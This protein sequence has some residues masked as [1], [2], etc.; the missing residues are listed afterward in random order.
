MGNRSGCL[1][2][3]LAAQ[4]PGGHTGTEIVE[5]LAKA[6]PQA[7]LAPDAVGSL[8]LHI[9]AAQHNADIARLL[10]KLCPQALT[11]ADAGGYLPLH[12]AIRHHDGFFVDMLLVQHL[13]EAGPEAL[14][15]ADKAGELPLHT[16]VHHLPARS[17]KPVIKHFLNCAPQAAAR[18]ANDGCLPL[19]RALAGNQSVAVV[20]LLLDA[21]PSATAAANHD[22]NL[23][24]HLA[25]QHCAGDFASIKELIRLHPSAAAVAN[26]LG[27]LPLHLAARHLSGRPGGVRAL[28][29]LLAAHPAAAEVAVRGESP[30]NT[31]DLTVSDYAKD[32]LPLHFVAYFSE[33]T[34]GATLAERLVAARPATIHWQTGGLKTALDL[35]VDR[36]RLLKKHKRALR[37]DDPLKTVLKYAAMFGGLGRVG[38]G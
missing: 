13:A 34:E 4:C 36:T 15:I 18:P 9:A 8:P 38:V 29:L 31:K 1:P 26:K 28:T 20:K 5:L 32:W 16:A 7:A 19:H 24:L 23:P 11:E 33:G 30:D 14:L 6:K 25:I 3:H 35:A 27:E 12:I 2:L 37:P 17:A 21:L 22:G 10:A